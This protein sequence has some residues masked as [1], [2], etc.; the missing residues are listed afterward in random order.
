MSNIRKGKGFIGC[1]LL[2]LVMA[3]VAIL[4]GMNFV[5][6]STNKDTESTFDGVN[7]KTTTTHTDF[8]YFNYPYQ[9]KTDLTN[10]YAILRMR[11]RTNRTTS[12]TVAFTK[13]QGEM[14]SKSIDQNV[15]IL[16]VN[17]DYSYNQTGTFGKWS[18]IN[19]IPAWFDGYM[20]FKVQSSS[21]TDFAGS[22]SLRSQA[23]A[24]NGWD[25]DFGELQV[26]STAL[27]DD[28]A[29]VWG[30][31][32]ASATVQ[33]KNYIENAQTV[34]TPVDDA[35]GNGIAANIY[36][37]NK[38]N[39]GGTYKRVYGKKL[40]SD[41]DGLNIAFLS[42]SANEKFFWYTY[43]GS[44]NE[45]SYYSTGETLREDGYLA[46]RC[47][48]NS[49]ETAKIIM[50]FTNTTNANKCLRIKSGQTIYLVD[51]NGKVSDTITGGNWG[52]T[53]AIPADFDGYMVMKLNEMQN[54]NTFNF[55]E[56][57]YF[58]VRGARNYAAIDMDFGNACLWTGTLG[59]ENDF[60]SFDESLIGSS[61]I[62]GKIAGMLRNYDSGCSAIFTPVIGVDREEPSADYNSISGSFD[63]LNI[64]VGEGATNTWHYVHTKID[65]SKTSQGSMLAY[66]IRTRNSVEPYV[67]LA[68]YTD[69]LADADMM[70]AV[71]GQEF[72]LYDANKNYLETRKFMAWGFLKLPVGFDGYLVT[73]LDSFGET[74][75]ISYIS[76]LNRVDLSEGMSLDMGD[77]TLHTDF[78]Q[79]GTIWGINYEPSMGG[80]C[81][82]DNRFNTNE[83]VK[84]SRVVKYNKEVSYAPVNGVQLESDSHAEFGIQSKAS[85][86]KG[87]NV[88]VAYV[89]N[90]RYKSFDFGVKLQFSDG[91][92]SN[93][94]MVY[95]Y[96]EDGNA[97]SAEKIPYDYSGYLYIPVNTF[98]VSQE[99]LSSV[100]SVIFELSEGTVIVR[101]IVLAT[102]LDNLD[103][104]LQISKYI[105]E[106]DACN[107]EQLDKAVG[108]IGGN[109]KVAS[110]SY[111]GATNHP[112]NYKISNWAT[113]TGL[114][115]T[116][117]VRVEEG[118]PIYQLDETEKSVDE[119]GKNE[120]NKNGYYLNAS[121]LPKQLSDVA[122]PWKDA[123][124]YLYAAE[125]NA[126]GQ[127]V[128]EGTI[129]IIAPYSSMEY[130]VSNGWDCV[131][132]AYLPIAEGL[133]DAWYFVKECENNEEIDGTKFDYYMII[134]GYI[135]YYNENDEDNRTLY[136]PH[137]DVAP[138]IKLSSEEGGLPKYAKLGGMNGIISAGLTK[139]DLS[140]G[141]ERFFA[142]F[143][144]S[145]SDPAQDSCCV[146]CY[147]DTGMEE[148]IPLAL[149]DHVYPMAN[150]NGNFSLYK[151]D[152][153]NLGV[154][155][156]TN[157]GKTQ[158]YTGLWYA[159]LENVTG[160]I[161]DISTTGFS[162]I[163]RGWAMH[164][165]ITVSATNEL[166]FSA[167]GET[168]TGSI[169]DRTFYIY[170][171]N[172]NGKT[173]YLKS[174]AY[175][176]EIS[177]EYAACGESQ[178]VELADG[179]LA[180]WARTEEYNITGSGSGT[181][182]AYSYDNGISWTKFQDNG[183]YTGS[184][185]FTVVRLSNGDLL[186]I[187]VSDPTS[188]RTHM[189]AYLSTNNGESWDYAM[190]LDQRYLVIDPVV[191]VDDDGTI[192]AMTCKT[193]FGAASEVRWFEFT[194]ADI[195]AGDFVTENA[196]RMEI[197]YKN[198]ARGQIESVTGYDSELFLYNVD[199]N[200]PVRLIKEVAHDTSDTEIIAQLPQTLTVTDSFG[201]TYDVNGTWERGRY[202]NKA[203]DSDTVMFTFVTTDLP[204]NVDD[205]LYLL[206]VY[207]DYD[208]E[209][210]FA[211]GSVD[212]ADN[213]VLHLYMDLA[214]E[215]LE[216]KEAYLNVE[217]PNGTVEKLLVK[218]SKLDGVTGYYKFAVN[219]A[220][221]EIASNIK[222]YIVYG[223]DTRGT[224]Y[225][226]SVKAY[227]QAILDNE[228]GY[229]ASVV[230]MAK[231]MLNY[232]SYAQVYFNFNTETLA[233]AEM[234]DLD[235]A[236]TMPNISENYKFIQDGD[237][238]GLSY[239]GTSLMAK[240]ETSIR[241]YFTLEAGADISNYI[242][243]YNDQTL[244]PINKGNMYY[245]EI[246]GIATGNL[247]KF[248]TLTVVNG[249]E[250]YS[251][252]YSVYTYIK[253]V[254][255]SS[256]YADPFKNMMAA[257][258]AY[259]EAAEACIQ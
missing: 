38:A 66:R 50:M 102:T 104:M 254:I 145:S 3:I 162:K 211:G 74:K 41:F 2:A 7:L 238:T 198:P 113:I 54:L 68:A 168:F 150:A 158:W 136:I 177:N 47:K 229:S 242:F 163:G 19:N 72:Y 75:D 60:S 96:D 220:A 108:T 245:V 231:A 240:A 200:K 77:I 20:I 164:E 209:D 251:I 206:S 124:T 182:V 147:R 258:Y 125:N 144:L 24:N 192:Y 11:N 134:G 93:A 80:K 205:C 230:G 226:Y 99:Q 87:N 56:D 8:Y 45:V 82:P 195:M 210:T 171:S 119:K 114:E 166:I 122:E 235:K 35:Q 59:A 17:A 157:C 219:V 194:T 223:D 53:N 71:E 89:S 176:G 155:V 253:T 46:V 232:G 129:M 133:D 236:I 40:Y 83:A 128:S 14:G 151:T 107:G 137:Y 213:I 183:V 95:Y 91:S 76:I 159:I 172:D 52:W 70:R 234:D 84:I 13:S 32:P 97:V 154:L 165:P 73:S 18:G 218:E 92:K 88:I 39:T 203:Y 221:K 86:Y 179:V 98:S 9:D 85:V 30:T 247:S 1:V 160:D 201:N 36:E 62:D 31:D 239:H 78:S 44:G 26:S 243:T 233:N 224:E 227:A 199:S 153:G 101:D 135:N 178:I 170:A 16:F 140:N 33:L 249:E 127:V 22:I 57:Y 217:L 105:F 246:S 48:N 120:I 51:K 116:K 255:E 175:T 81:S 259:G 111:N 191:Y 197:L 61:V 138:F 49:S 152:D 34:A 132:S 4:G 65:E 215:T 55:N 10:Q 23:S 216:D 180:L 37:F 94:G 121:S 126:K 106:F 15:P 187:S 5:K 67:Q 212:L 237:V 190:T 27:P 118:Y 79:E 146:I 257:V 161:A 193:R 69:S 6:A 225:T 250:T 181:T 100:E 184:T 103:T 143:W 12:L 196:S 252:T 241:H 148:W 174:S 244:T 131:I 167:V 63:G 42:D 188:R 256:S 202:N 28:I 248:H 169:Y 25:Y 208:K 149:A 142:T 29:N 139:F 21:N 207:V 64:T 173:W 156:S 214:K 189:M 110:N 141:G 117:L 204:N 115:N 186:R 222:F 185:I 90:A 228:A 123:Y 43:A 112:D 109:V 130:L 58:E